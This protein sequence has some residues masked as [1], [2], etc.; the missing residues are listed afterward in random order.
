MVPKPQK[1]AWMKNFADVEAIRSKIIIYPTDTVYGIGGNAENRMAVEKIF[2]IKGRDR[3]K[4]LSVIAPGKEWILRHCLVSPETID[5][6]L[7]GNY[8]LL[9]KK[10]DREFLGFAT[11]GSP[12]IGVRIPAHRFSKLVEEAGVPFITTSANPSGGKAPKSLSEIPGEIRDAANIIIDGGE[13]P[14]VPSTIVD[15]TGA[16]EVIVE[17]A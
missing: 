17:R 12:N 9:L 1:L 14:G 6:Y 4:P 8:T 7:P 5:K 13:L 10:K 11:A 3:K 16:E 2:A 15:C